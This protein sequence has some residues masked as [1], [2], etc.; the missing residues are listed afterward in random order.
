[1]FKGYCE[2]RNSTLCP[3]G[4]I[5]INEGPTC[6]TTCA[7]YRKRCIVYTLVPAKG[8]YCR[9]GSAR[10]NNGTC[11]RACSP[12]CKAQYNHTTNNNDTPYSGANCTIQSN[13]N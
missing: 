5:F 13:E 4:E 11:A 7:N 6:D 9:G 3:K 2:D 1:M 8:C 12:D 10:L